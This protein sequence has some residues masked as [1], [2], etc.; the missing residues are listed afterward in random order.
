MELRQ[1]EYF[2][3]VCKEMHFS[4]A[5]EKLC[6]TQSNLSQQIKFLEKEL[7]VQLFDRMGKRIALTDA[8]RVMMEQSQHIFSHIKYAREAIEEIKNAKGGSLKIGVLPGDADLLFDALVVEFHRT[9]PKISLSVIETTKISEEVSAGTIDI[10]IT[11]P[12]LPDKKMTI[13]PLFHEEFALAIRSDHPLALKKEIP[14]SE[15][16]TLKMVMFAPDHQ[17]R[18]LITRYC[19][20]EGFSLDPQIETTTL[21]SLLSLVIQ[22]I[23][24]C[25]LPR[26]LLENLDQD[27]IT[28]ISLINP[29]PSQDICVI[30]RSDRFMGFAARTFI[31]TLHAYIE[32]AKNRVILE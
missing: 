20:R 26:L 32:E 21:S 25:I 5:A 2:L 3:A 7:G 22:G 1:L 15:L 27:E 31:N 8:G 17:I 28:I 29:T 12:P 30:Y 14:F 4:R 19:L 11:T 6:T 13:I 9:Y 24:A 23:G 16:Q 18:Q 10:G